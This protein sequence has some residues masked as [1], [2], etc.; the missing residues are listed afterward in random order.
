[1]A[2]IELQ[3]GGRT[4]Y[5][6]HARVG[7]FV[8]LMF[9]EGYSEPGIH[10]RVERTEKGYN[11]R[12]APHEGGSVMPACLG[13]LEIEVDK[14]GKGAVLKASKEMKVEVSKE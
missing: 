7:D 11:V 14:D 2:E 4:E 3:D 6:A 8:T 9:A 5:I 13:T 12:L 10:V 1:M